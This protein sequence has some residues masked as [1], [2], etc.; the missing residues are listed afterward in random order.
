MTDNYRLFI[1][2]CYDTVIEDLQG[3]VEHYQERLN[4]NNETIQELLKKWIK[5]NTF[6]IEKLTEQRNNI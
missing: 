5:E 4:K 3:A 1:E 6:L 2:V